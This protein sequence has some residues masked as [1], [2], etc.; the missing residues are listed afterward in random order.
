[1]AGK[2][3][4]RP[5]KMM[6]LATLAS[7]IAVKYCGNVIAASWLAMKV[8]RAINRQRDDSQTASYYAIKVFAVP[9]VASCSML[10]VFLLLNLLRYLE[11]L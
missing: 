6:T 8:A 1:M 10:P 3:G 2:L 5:K 9:F 7:P 4:E 11:A